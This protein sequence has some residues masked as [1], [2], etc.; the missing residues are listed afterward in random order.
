VDPDQQENEIE[1]GKLKIFLNLNEDVKKE[2][3]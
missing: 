1:E 2:I 3:H